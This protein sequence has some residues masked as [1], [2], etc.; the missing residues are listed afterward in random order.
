[1]GFTGSKGDQ[2]DTGFTGSASTVPG[3][4]GFTGSKGEPGAA[5][6][7]SVTTDTSNFNGVLSPSD[8]NVQLALDTI[9]DLAYVSDVTA[10]IGIDVVSTG[11][12]REINLANTAV[13]S[14]TYGDSSNVAQVTV[15]NQ[16]QITA[17]SNVALVTSS[18]TTIERFKINYNAAGEIISVTN[19]TSGVTVV[20]TDGI[21]GFIEITLDAKYVYPQAQLTFFGYDQPNDRYVITALQDTNPTRFIAGNS[22]N[23]FD[24]LTQSVTTLLANKAETH[25]SAD[26]GQVT[27][28]YIQLTCTTV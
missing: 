28:A 22:G 18:T 21:N 8:T 3:P 17:V 11:N 10:G 27:H 5:D 7:A 23:L 9:D 4:V 15:N 20:I 1:M 24:G 14:G 13:T 12:D 2:G 6:A 26:F 25:A 16:G 19:E